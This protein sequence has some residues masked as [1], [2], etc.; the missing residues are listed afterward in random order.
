MVI[1][2]QAGLQDF[3]S[4]IHNGVTP[5]RATIATGL[6]RSAAPIFIRSSGSG[7][8]ARHAVEGWP[9]VVPLYMTP[10][11]TVPP[12]RLGQGAGSPARMSEGSGCK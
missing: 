12:Q 7:R 2:N 5:H 4:G 6:A 9:A 8:G 3:V 10:V 11:L 1:P